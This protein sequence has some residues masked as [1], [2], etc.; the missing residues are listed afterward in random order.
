[1]HLLFPLISSVLYVIAALFLK[2]AAEN[3]VG[4]R[5][6][7]FVCNWVTALLFLVLLPVGGAVPSVGHLWQPA[8][9]ALL[10]FAGQLLTLL[11]LDKG[12]VSVATP[13]LGA[14]VVL[15]AV[16]T[17]LLL[18][19]SVRW[20]LWIAAVMSCLGIGLLNRNDG[21]GR[22]GEVG[23]TICLALVAAAAYAL[24]DVLVMKWS[25]AWGFGRFLPCMLWINGIYSLALVPYFRGPLREIRPAARGPLLWGSLCIATQALVLVTTLAHFGDGTAVNVVYSSRGLWGVL[26]VWLFGR[27]FNNTEHQLGARTLR[28]R[29]AGAFLLFSAIG[30]IFI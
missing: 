17:T 26:A 3:G 9:V 8:V 23:R 5:R 10:F 25:P 27:W 20:Q 18:D 2:Q 12:D 14:K 28:W 29:L 30:L 16:L 13:V 15:V 21:D 4:V 24:F 6:A 1:M 19:Q 7:A 22:R 11:A